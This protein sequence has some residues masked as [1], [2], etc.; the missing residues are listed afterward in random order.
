MAFLVAHEPKAH[1]I[2][3]LVMIL[4]DTGPQVHLS[5]LFIK[6]VKGVEVYL[7]LSG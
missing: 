6:R 7:F 5:L 3:H 2:L 4:P 1:L